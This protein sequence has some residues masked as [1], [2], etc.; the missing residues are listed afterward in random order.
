MTMEYLLEL[1]YCLTIWKGYVSVNSEGALPPLP[2]VFEFL[3]KNYQ[4]LF[5]VGVLHSYPTVR[6]RKN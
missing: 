1:V 3:Q 5:Y 6:A 4:I 2:R